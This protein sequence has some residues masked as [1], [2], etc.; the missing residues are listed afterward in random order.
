VDP[1]GIALFVGEK[2]FRSAAD[3]A[4]NPAWRGRK[5]IIGKKPGCAV[6]ANRGSELGKLPTMALEFID[7]LGLA[8]GSLTTVSFI[9]QV[10]KIWRSR[11]AE[12]VSFGMFFLF[13]LGVLLWLIYGLV[14]DAVPIIAA[15][16]I[17]LILALTVVVLKLR[18]RQNP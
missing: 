4:G 13:S 7:G 10:V 17:T 12:D 18:Y 5:K 6:L 9:P 14:L 15:N 16:G 11:S 1:N 2:F 8:A 3:A